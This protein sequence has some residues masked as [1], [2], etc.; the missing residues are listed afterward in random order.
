MALELDTLILAALAY[1]TL[2][3]LIAE[4]TERGWVPRR[5]AEHPWVHALS[6]GVY[7]TS[8]SYFGS[9]GFAEREG[10]AYLG[11]YLGAT[12]AGL[13]VPFV[14]RPLLALVEAR[15]LGS[16][17]DVLAYRYQSP[18]VGA[19]TT[20]LL[21]GGSLP[22][23]AL[24]I[25]AIVGAVH[26]VTG[27]TSAWLAPGYA[28]GVAAFAAVFGARHARVRTRHPGLVVAMAVESVVKL[29]ALLGV[30]YAAVYGV[31]GSPAALDA[32]LA[33]HPEAVE[34][35]MAPAREGSWVSLV[36]LSFAAAYLLPRQFHLAFTEAPSPRAL[37][38]SGWLVPAYLWLLTLA[39]PLVV[40]AGRMIDPDG[41]ADL[42]VLQVVAGSPALTVLTFLGGLSASS[43]MIIVTSL[44][45]AGMIQ[46]H[47][48]LPVVRVRWTDL[49]GGLARLRR[50]LVV[51]VIAAG[52]AVLYVLPPAGA[53]ADLGLLS[54]VSIAQL[55]PPLAGVLYWRRATALGVGLGLFGGNA[56]WLWLLVAPPSHDPWTW[57]TALSLALNTALFL[58]GS[59]LRP[60]SDE[61]AD[62]AVVCT[63]GARGPRLMPPTALDTPALVERLAPI[64]GHA[65]AEA[66]VERARAAHP[67]DDRAARR[68]RVDRLEANLSGLLGPVIARLAVGDATPTAREVLLEQVRFFEREGAADLRGRAGPVDAV[69]RWL[70][71]VLEALPLGVAVVARDGEIV[72]WNEAMQRIGGVPSERAV[73][74]PIAAL[75]GELAHALDEAHRSG[76][77]VERVVGGRTLQLLASP[78]SDGE[79]GWVLLAE[80]HTEQRALEAQV[81][82]QERLAGVGRLSAGVAHEI[83]NPL[84][85]ILMLARR[86]ARDATTEDVREDA[87][88]IAHEAERIHGIVQALVGF[89]RKDTDTSALADLARVVDDALGLVRLARREHTVVWSVEC[90]RPLWVQG[91]ASRLAQVLVNLLSNAAEASPAGA[92]IEVR[93]ARV[94]GAVEVAVVD[95]GAGVPPALR[96]QIFEPFFTTKPHGRGTGLGLAIAYG[97]VEAHGGTLRLEDTPGGG[98]TFVVRLPAAAESGAEAA[99]KRA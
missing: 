71:Q 48:F 7:A 83:G 37:E 15:Q 2:L 85:G 74:R 50:A 18:R 46:T 25:R 27:A 80:D 62:A 43:A 33:A 57:A 38:V 26:A 89:S 78:L 63:T 22:Y 84:T 70:R 41:S 45:L 42:H 14:W 5:V 10:L 76:E 86:L 77:R 4:A 32:W 69:R 66:E 52:A 65:A 19:L 53:L 23:L 97:L 12:L 93:A 34:T 31:F 90:E 67:G 60:P 30:A 92:A 44:A 39:V 1:L 87:A 61:A 59:W 3:V 17:A 54:F 13:A 11:I 55:L 21:V 16:L 28:L 49:H 6:L 51:G 20:V 36:V 75:G 81:V 94:A 95:H 72:L 82:H 8:W 73:G 79:R 47:L 99:V 9:V 56:V 58:V 96:T 40:W 91:D 24:Q 98:A 29:L 64:I 35:L 88:S 68:A